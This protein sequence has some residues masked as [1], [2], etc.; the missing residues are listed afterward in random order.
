[1][2]KNQIDYKELSE[3]LLIHVSEKFDIEDLKR[4]LKSLGYNTK[5]INQII[6]S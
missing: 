2:E 6:E 4:F 3:K 5:Q 1:V